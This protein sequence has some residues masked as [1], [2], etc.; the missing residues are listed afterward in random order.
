MVMD[1]SSLNQGVCRGCRDCRVVLQYQLKEEDDPNAAPGLDP[2]LKSDLIGTR[3]L[4]ILAAKDD[5]FLTL[6]SLAVKSPEAMTY[7]KAGGKGLNWHRENKF[8]VLMLAV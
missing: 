7:K 4:N 8:H 5:L 1:I 3:P 6:Q 2:V